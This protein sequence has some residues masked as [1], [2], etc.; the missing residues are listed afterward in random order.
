M[1]FSPFVAIEAYCLL[2][3]TEAKWLVG[4]MAVRYFLFTTT[5]MLSLEMHIKVIKT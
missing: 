2:A 4:L 3:G 5:G 1:F